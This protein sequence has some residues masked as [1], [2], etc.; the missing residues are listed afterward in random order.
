LGVM[1]PV[2]AA[3]LADTRRRLREWRRQGS[4]FERGELRMFW[5]RE[6]ASEEQMANLRRMIKENSALIAEYD[7]E[8]LTDDGNIEIADIGHLSPRQ[9]FAGKPVTCSLD[10]N[11]LAAELQI[12]DSE[13]TARYFASATPGRVAGTVADDQW[14]IVPLDGPN[15]AQEL[16]DPLFWVLICVNE[17]RPFDRVRY[18]EVVEQAAV[19]DLIWPS[20]NP[21]EL[22]ENGI[23]VLHEALQARRESGRLLTADPLA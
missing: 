11:G 1:T 3:L 13:E 14:S 19:R 20:S 10:D 6:D 22:R 15:L 7:P 21:R 23:L 4:L 18:R 16:S 8:N 9:L 2:R 17:N 5:G 12:Y